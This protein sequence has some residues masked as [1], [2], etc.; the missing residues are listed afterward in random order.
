MLL[1]KT[2]ILYKHILKRLIEKYNCFIYFKKSLL[3]YSRAPV[4]L[5]SLVLFDSHYKLKRKEFSFIINVWMFF[6]RYKFN[7]FIWFFISHAWCSMKM[8]IR[9]FKKKIAYFKFS[10]TLMLVLI[11]IFFQ[12]HQIQSFIFI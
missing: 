11:Y 3:Y 5:F 6:L 12:F 8:H 4:F 1:P 10:W 2:P 9:S 7:M